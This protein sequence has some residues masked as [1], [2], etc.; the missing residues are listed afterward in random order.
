VSRLV[1][2][3]A[4]IDVQDP[5]DGELDRLA[6]EF[7]LH[8]LAVEDAREG[9]QRP[10]FEGYDETLFV[11]LKPVRY[12]EEE[13]R[14]DIDEVDVFVGRDFLVSVRYRDQ[15]DLETVRERFEGDDDLL[16]CGPAAILHAILDHVVDQYLPVVDELEKD[17]SEV[18]AEVFSAGRSNP[19]ERIYGLKRQVLEFHRAV[20]GLVAG[21]D[22]LARGRH[23]LVPQPLLE[24][25]RDV[26][27]HLLHIV[28][29]IETLREPLT[30]VLDANLAQVGV[31]QNEDVRKISAWV[32]ILAV[33]T[34]IAASTA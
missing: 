16:R 21:L 23:D 33:P 1:D 15:K 13:E 27:D 4:W 32:A 25:F 26:H 18:E 10:K 7:G 20:A 24:Y 14:L 22:M 28:G 12:L 2:S 19:T 5:D 11:V 6:Q 9:H 29:R 8:D 17:V 3:P 34:M 31:R 30:G